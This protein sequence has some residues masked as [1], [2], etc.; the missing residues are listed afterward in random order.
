[1]RELSEL[2][3]DL[4]NPRA[5]PDYKAIRVVFNPNLWL[6]EWLR[7]NKPLAATSGASLEEEIRHRSQVARSLARTIFNAAQPGYVF[8]SP[9]AA[10]PS[11]AAATQPASEEKSKIQSSS[12]DN[13]QPTRRAGKDAVSSG[14]TPP[15]AY[16]R[17][18]PAAERG[19]FQR[20]NPSNVLHEEPL[21]SSSVNQAPQPQADERLS[22]TPSCPC[23]PS[24]TY[25]PDLLKDVAD[26]QAK[27]SPTAVASAMLTLFLDYRAALAKLSNEAEVKRLNDAQRAYWEQLKCLASLPI[28]GSPAA[29]IQIKT[30]GSLHFEHIFGKISPAATVKDTITLAEL[31]QMIEALAI[32]RSGVSSPLYGKTPAIFGVAF[33]LLSPEM[34]PESIRPVGNRADETCGE[35]V[36]VQESND[37]AENEQ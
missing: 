31:S 11:P 6:S 18:G 5:P 35:D 25:Y 29:L 4:H 16:H 13:G 22:S 19:K 24:S 33:E 3:N 12:E 21:G 30:E 15:T 2:L 8:Q 14:S 23:N 17:L 9:L 32:Q 27:I 1:V 10:K 7:R 36:Q 28:F 37:D 26:S 34:D 20:K